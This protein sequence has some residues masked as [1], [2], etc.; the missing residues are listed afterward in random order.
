MLIHIDTIKQHIETFLRNE[1][2]ALDSEWHNAVAHFAQFIEGKQAEIDAENLLKSKGY[3]VTPPV[4][5]A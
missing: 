5:Q 2:Q 3:T 1:G 4:T